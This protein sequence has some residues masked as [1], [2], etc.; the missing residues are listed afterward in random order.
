ML[1]SNQLTYLCAFI[2][3]FFARICLKTLQWVSAVSCDWNSSESFAF[4]H[5]WKWIGKGKVFG[6]P[7][8]GVGLCCRTTGISGRGM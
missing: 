5:S 6:Y 7:A 1:I 3:S 2:S 8:K 4:A